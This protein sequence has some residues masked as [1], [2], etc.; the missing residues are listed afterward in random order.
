MK[1][2]EGKDKEIDNVSENGGENS[3]DNPL[4]ESTDSTDLGPVNEILLINDILINTNFRN[5][6]N[7]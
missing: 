5:K 3:D 6:E 2:D 1:I 4:E 7:A